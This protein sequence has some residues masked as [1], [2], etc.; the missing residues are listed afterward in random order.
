M[1]YKIK[2]AYITVVVSDIGGELQSIQN[3]ERIEYLWQGDERYWMG[4]AVNIFPYVGRLTDGRYSLHGSVYQMDIH[5]FIKSSK[6]VAENNK[7]DSISFCFAGT[8][9]TRDTYPYSFVYRIH[10]KLNKNSVKISYEVNNR[11]N[12]TMYFGL[13]GH[14]GFNVPLQKG[15]DFSDYYLEFGQERGP[16]KVGMSNECF[17]NGEDMPFDL[18]EGRRL[19]LKH[20]LFDNDAI[21]LKDMD[22]KVTLK[23]KKDNKSVTVLYPQMNYLGLWHTPNTDAPYICIEP[24]SSCPSRQGVIEELEKQS[25]L[26]SIA[27]GEVYTNT[28]EIVID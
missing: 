14:P 10:Y 15:L 1:N 27:A 25:D 19:L 13:G 20:E 18:E 2:N 22:T 9:Q 8:A 6:M 16:I 11:D 28:W 5:G 21:I 23:S 17:V 24:W 26:I 4:K 3:I 7:S 12:K